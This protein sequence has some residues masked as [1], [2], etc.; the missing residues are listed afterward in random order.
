MINGNELISEKYDELS[1][2]LLENI[3]HEGVDKVTVRS[4]IGACAEF[5]ETGVSKNSMVFPNL[6]QA[7]GA[8]S[9]KFSNIRFNLK[10]AFDIILL[11]PSKP[12][13]SGIYAKL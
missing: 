10:I 9:V 2:Y 4:L 3:K 1:E 7:G 8:V 6:F 5:G 13:E 12:F 11:S